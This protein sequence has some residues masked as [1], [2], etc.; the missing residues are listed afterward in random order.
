VGTR[1]SEKI[2]LIL[3]VAKTHSSSRGWALTSYLD[4]GPKHFVKIEYIKIIK[5]FGTVPSAKNV[6][7]LFY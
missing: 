6:K 1:T 7:V 4:L 2:E 5:A 3:D